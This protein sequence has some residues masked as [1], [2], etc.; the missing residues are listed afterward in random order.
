[1]RVQAVA[2][3][4][5]FMLAAAEARRDLRSVQSAVEKTRRHLAK[6]S[7]AA[8][9]TALFDIPDLRLT[10][11]NRLDR[12][13]RARM[14]CRRSLWRMQLAEGTT[15]ADIA[16]AWGLSRQLVSRALASSDTKLSR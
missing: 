13:E 4:D 15:I 11:T 6:G 16:R 2:D 7:R 3:L 10:L 12:L 9:L 8:D 5:E 1:M 14:A